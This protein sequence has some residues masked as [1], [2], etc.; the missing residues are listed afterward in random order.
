MKT[1]SPT[2]VRKASDQSEEMHQIYDKLVYWL[3]N[4]QKVHRARLFADRLAKLLARFS[5][6]PESI[7]VEECRSLVCEAKGDLANAIKH[8]ENEIRLIRRLHKISQDTPSAD[9]VFSQYDYAGLSDRLDLLAMLYRDKGN[10]DK[11]IRILHESKQLCENHGIDFDGDDI[12]Q[13]YL[14]EKKSNSAIHHPDGA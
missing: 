9:F 7:F 14:R 6:T 4:R 11:A 3:Y 10:L 12:L 8:R 2:S 5:R 1:K 13:E